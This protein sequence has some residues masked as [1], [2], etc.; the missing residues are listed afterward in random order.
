MLCNNRENHP[1]GGKMSSGVSDVWSSFT[2]IEQEELLKYLY[3]P[4]EVQDEKIEVKN[5]CI[6]LGGDTIDTDG[7]I[8]FLKDQFP[9]FVFPEEKVEEM[10]MPM[11]EAQRRAGMKSDFIRDGTYG[12][13][14]LF[15]LVDGL[16]DIPMVC[17]K[18]SLQANPLDEQKGSDGV[19]YGQYNGEETL[20]MGEAK[21]YSERTDAI[22]DALDSTSRFHGPDGDRMRRNEL[23]VASQNLT[24]NLSKSRI[25]ELAE[26]L[27][28][29]SPDYRLIHP[30]FIGYE[31]EEL[32][33][34]QTEPMEEEELE[35]R[36]FDFVEEERDV[37]EYIKEKVEED[38]EDLQ[39][40]WLIFILLPVNNSDRFKKRMKEAIFP[41]STT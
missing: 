29:P 6:A 13:L 12:E 16:L 18:L 32:H 26:I 41:Y 10:D 23:N 34:L 35:K 11:Y 4:N 8:E 40:H 33:E 30:I 28:N 17:H 25:E 37:I 14:I 3:P 9:L 36:I 27:T 7:F 31:S 20:G 5:C 2:V 15:T 39:R 22:R 19:F 24:Q 21:F 38:Y 1:S